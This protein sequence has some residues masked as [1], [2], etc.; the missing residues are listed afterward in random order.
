[1]ASRNNEQQQAQ[2]FKLQSLDEYVIRMKWKGD[3]GDPSDQLISHGFHLS[4]I[5]I[6][7][8]KCWDCTV[9]PQAFREM[10]GKHESLSQQ[11]FAK[12][13]KSA[14]Y[15]LPDSRGRK[16]ECIL[17]EDEDNYNN[18]HLS[19]IV[20]PDPDGDIQFEIATF[21]LTHI[22]QSRRTQNIWEEFIL[23]LVEDR[24]A[25]KEKIDEL[26]RR[27]KVMLRD[28]RTARESFEGVA[29][30]KEE[31]ELEIYKTFCDLLNAKKKKIRELM[32]ALE[33]QESL[34]KE[35]E[36]NRLL[37]TNGNEGETAIPSAS[38]E[39][40][41]KSTTTK[42][43]P[44]KK[45]K[46][47]PLPS[48]VRVTGSIPPTQP[49]QPQGAHGTGSSRRAQQSRDHPSQV[50]HE[51]E[52]EDGGDRMAIDT[53]MTTKGRN[54]NGNDQSPLFSS[55]SGPS[56]R[57]AVNVNPP[58]SDSSPLINNRKKKDMA[59]KMEI[60]NP[61]PVVPLPLPLP[62]P[63]FPSSRMNPGDRGVT[64]IVSRRKPAASVSSSVD[65]FP[66]PAP[67]QGSSS[68]SK[69]TNAN[70]QAP[71]KS[72]ESSPAASPALGKSQSGSSQSLLKRLR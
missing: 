43:P 3:E 12:S 27:E 14:L 47:T 63:L 36:Q 67:V 38:A 28:L 51:D 2:F 42:Q 24:R 59:V 66:A 55:D 60:D 52:D 48:T 62:T 72:E 31:A 58:S 1:M 65:L 61:E 13:V 45:S 71:P 54:G 19:I 16:T 34:R 53:P 35:A 23:F 57:G 25:M 29:A 41:T 8:G 69:N 10:A 40:T 32:A 11:D 6:P 56:K 22:Q 50:K 15:G 18:F 44:T 21:E 26:E 46:A 33:E 30:Q 64:K 5:S 37:I 7:L 49:A 4:M 39:T 70:N 17:R 9:T 20:F 68:S